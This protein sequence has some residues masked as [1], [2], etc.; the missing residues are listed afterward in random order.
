MLLQIGR[1]ASGP[2]PAQ[3]RAH[4]LVRQSY[5]FETTHG[6]HVLIVDGSRVYAIDDETATA[7]RQ[8]PANATH[9]LEQLGLID[10]ERPF[11]TN[12]APRSMAVRS[13]S[14][15]I[16]QKCNLAC[17]YCYAQEG[18]FGAGPRNMDREA[19]LASLDLLFRDVAA[20]E[21][22][23][24]AFLGGEPLVNRPLLRECTE[25]A[26]EMGQ[27]RSVRT[28]FSITTNGTLVEPS[29]GDFFERHGFAVT[30]SVDGV[31]ETHDK[32]RP[33]R[34]G[35]GSYARILQSVRPLLGSQRRMQVSARVTVTPGNLRL[36]E[37]LDT[38]LSLGFHSVG[39]SPMLHAPSGNDEMS[40]MALAE[41]LD[42]MIDCG[43]EFVRRTA[44][45]ERYAFANLAT[46]VQQIHKGTH[47]PY[48]CGAGGGYF[49]VAAGGDLHAC[50]RFVEDP[51]G[52][53][54]D[55]F[56]GVDPAAQERWL[57]E[58]HVHAQSP[59]SGCWARYLCGG[60]CH[61]EVIHRGRPACDY[62][63]GWLDYSLKAYVRLRAEAPGYFA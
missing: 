45:G 17:T 20:G 58:R 44:L 54:G 4:D 3:E 8:D 22:V 61:H 28:S 41:M 24:L 10:P 60:G 18:S 2:K 52:R 9:T 13:L 29:D 56:G 59:C 39:F 14:L 34:G 31:G 11:I 37:T 57:A 36:R 26:A 23:N 43:E 53:L 19:A 50:H 33:L 16:A 51:R 12:D 49:G 62:I 63:R 48:P 15:A 38:L 55:V 42:Q 30:I 21:S 32:Q 35:Q 47:R 7:L 1:G 27:R 46:A 25:R 5:V 6:V 40:Q